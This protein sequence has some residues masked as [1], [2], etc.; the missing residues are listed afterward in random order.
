MLK[1]TNGTSG[2]GALRVGTADDATDVGDFVA[3]LVGAS[4][5]FYDQST[6]ILNMYNSSNVLSVV[7]NAAQGRLEALARDFGDGAAGASLFAGR[8]TN[9]TNP[10]AGYL[11]LEANDGTDYYLWVDAAG[12]LRIHTSP[13]TTVNDTAGTIVGNQS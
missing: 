5:L 4:R 2:G 1:V 12:K 3:G 10:G 11:Q 6:S 13:P 8:N 9:G 7:A